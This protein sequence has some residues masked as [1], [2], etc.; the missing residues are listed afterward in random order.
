MND[1]NERLQVLGTSTRPSCAAAAGPNRPELSTQS[2]D[3]RCRLCSQSLVTVA[4]DLKA[5]L[6][7]LRGYIDLLASTKLGPLAPGQERALKEMTE[8]TEILRRLTDK[9]LIYSGVRAGIGLKLEEQDFNLCIADLV[10]M[11]APRFAKKTL[12]FY[13]LPAETLPMFA[14]DYYKT[15]HIISNLLDNAC[16][17]TPSGG[18]VWIQTSQYFWDRRASSVS[19]H[20][21]D[22]RGS[23]SSKPNC[24][25]IDVCD[26]GPG[27]PPENFQEI[28]EEFRQLEENNAHP[29]SMGLG[30]AIAKRLAEM[31]QGK[32]WVE[33]ELGNGS[34]FSFVLP[35]CR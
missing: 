13:W 25:R 27:I 7:V 33:S 3:D 2:T 35:Y 17:V 23:R 8:S 16:K 29:G 11:W 28:F 31:H 18:S 12:A 24:A 10:E 6:A 4:H 32:I 1:E 15:Q 34:R 30:L 22:R 5:P 9:F 20:G 19:Y 14:F 26:T 21:S